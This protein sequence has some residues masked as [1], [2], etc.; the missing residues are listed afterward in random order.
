MNGISQRALIFGVTG[1]DGALLAQYLLAQGFEVHGTS[2][3]RDDVAGNLHQLAIA[4]RVR[5]HQVDPL[6]QTQV[7]AALSAIGPS[8]VYNLSG[9]SSVG[10]SFAE[11]RETFESHVGSTMA[12][13]EALRMHA[14]GCRFFHASSSEI[15]GDTGETPANEASIADPRSPYGVAK[16]AATLLVESYRD[17]FGLFACSGFMFNHESPLR[18]D[19]FVTQ[20]IAHGAAAIK[21]KRADRLEL[22]NLQVVRDWGWAEDYVE[23]MA[24]MLQQDEPRDYVVATGVAS[25]LESFVDRVFGRFDLDW[26]DFVVV[27]DKLLRPNDISVS[28]GDSRLA[29]QRLGWR[30]RVRMPEVAERLADAALARAHG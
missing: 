28:V 4:A 30:A 6:D 25:S 11:P 9:Q 15:F 12:I 5:V 27:D 21:M 20:R 7:A 8:Q 16:A 10:R 2:R 18:P 1:Q 17:L 26:K 19:S 3:R 14:P 23:C 22:G 24:R 13:L 29:E